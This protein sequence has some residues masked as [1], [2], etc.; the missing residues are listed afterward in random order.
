MTS[1]AGIRTAA[2]AVMILLAAAPVQAHCDALDGPVVKAAEA[3]LKGGDV[4]PVL[5]WVT[6]EQEA[7]VRA[8]FQDALAVRVSGGRAQALADRYFFETVVRLHRQSEGEPF[9]GLQR[10]AG[11]TR[12]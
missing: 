8:P 3:A 5:R 2:A 4:T 12:S 10:P 6:R 9:T 11:S 7:E 1:S